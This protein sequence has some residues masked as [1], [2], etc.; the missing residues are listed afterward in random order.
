MDKLK[1]TSSPQKKMLETA[2]RADIGG[3]HF[4]GG[5]G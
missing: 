4:G 2:Y 3:A 1:K 5:Q